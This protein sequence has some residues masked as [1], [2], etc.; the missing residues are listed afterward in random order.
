MGVD[1]GTTVGLSVLDLEGNALDHFKEK[2][3]NSDVK[4]GDKKI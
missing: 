1:P 3:L 4:R 2:F